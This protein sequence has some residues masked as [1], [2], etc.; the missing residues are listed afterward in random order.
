MSQGGSENGTRTSLDI[1]N[2]VDGNLASKLERDIF[3]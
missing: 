2:D 1:L 3:H